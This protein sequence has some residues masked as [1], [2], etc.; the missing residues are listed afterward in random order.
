MSCEEVHDALP[1]FVLDIL[2][3]KARAA[4]ASHVVRCVTCRAELAATEE[5]AARLLGPLDEPADSPPARRHDTGDWD[6][7]GWD[8]EGREPEG[9]EPEEWEPSGD[10]VYY[11]PSE[12][13]YYQIREVESPQSRVGHGRSRLRMVVT[14]AAAGLLIVGTTLGP[15]LSAPGSRVVPV[16]QA[17]LLTSS[18]RTVGYVYFLPG[19]SH[20]VDVVVDGIGTFNALTLELIDS[21]GRFVKVGRFAVSQGRASW[22]APSS[23]AASEVSE[24]VVLGPSGRKVATGLVA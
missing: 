5:S 7:E 20:D 18:A 13:I 15:E 3:S 6:P 10:D 14:I 4:V 21:D 2:A 9:R 8:P 22:V 16:A 17:Q 23:V 11:Q 19:G 1:E 12:D 24:V